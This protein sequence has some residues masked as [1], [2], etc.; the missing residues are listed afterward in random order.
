MK[1]RAETLQPMRDLLQWLPQLPVTTDG[2]VN[3]ASDATLDPEVF[4]VVGDAAQAAMNTINRGVG[5]IG[6]LLAHSAVVIEDGT[7]SADCIESLGYFLSEIS[8]MSAGCMVLEARCRREARKL[9]PRVNLSLS[10]G[11]YGAVLAA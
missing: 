6:Q 2:Q 5:A 4:A 1:T 3:C 11:G 7:I 8:D 10:V 9:E